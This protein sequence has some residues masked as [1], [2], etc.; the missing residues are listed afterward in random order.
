M[1][2]HRRVGVLVTVTE[3]TAAAVAPAPGAAPDVFAG[4]AVT[5]RNKGFASVFLGGSGVTATTGFELAVGESLTSQLNQGERLYGIAA[6]AT[7]RV[8]VLEGGL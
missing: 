6:A 7:Q 8:D 5:L 1:L 4:G 2:A 3:I